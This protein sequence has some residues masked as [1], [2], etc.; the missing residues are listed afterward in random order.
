QFAK[1]IQIKYCNRNDI[2]LSFWKKEIQQIGPDFIY[3][4]NLFSP[5]FSILPLLA[6]RFSHI[7]TNWIL[8]PRGAL[9][10]SALAFKPL[11]KQIYLWV[12]R[13]LGFSKNIRFQTTDEQEAKDVKKYFGK[14]AA[15]YPAQNFPFARISDWQMRKKEV[16]KLHAVFFARIG[17]I[18]KLDYLLSILTEVDAEISLDIIGPIEDASFW[19]KCQEISKQFPSKVEMNY[20]GEFPHQEIM[21]KLKEY[22]LFCLPTSGENFGHAIFEAMAAGCPVL[23]SDQTPWRNLSEKKIGWDVD[24][25]DRE[26]FKD[27]LSL[28]LAMEQKEW[29]TWSR[30][31]WNFCKEYLLNSQ[32]KEQYMA[33][34][35]N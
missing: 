19:E 7:N 14:K 33:L 8:A 12:L 29:E 13:Y 15:V 2:S 18:K 11:K 22:H 4:N 10:V 6:K 3:L 24:L 27:S 34:F 28:A 5:H 20:L 16:G 25:N 26:K 35:S 32:T 1:G 31:S 9:R 23:I 21:N 30:A 17:P